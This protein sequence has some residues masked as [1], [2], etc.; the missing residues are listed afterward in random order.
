LIFQATSGSAGTP[1][2]FVITA[3]AEN[4]PAFTTTITTASEVLIH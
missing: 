3:E 1:F 2:G 4:V